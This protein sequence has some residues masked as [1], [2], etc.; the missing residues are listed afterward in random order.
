[1]EIFFIQ[2]ES[3][4]SSGSSDYEKTGGAYINCWVKALSLGAA[5]AIALRNIE[6]NRWKVIQLLDAYQITEGFRTEGD[7][8][9]GYCRQ[10]VLDGECYIYHKWPNEAQ[11]RNKLH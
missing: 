5:R 6:I 7:E 2:Y 4:P 3:V 9:S 11:E 1:M 8:M 10:A